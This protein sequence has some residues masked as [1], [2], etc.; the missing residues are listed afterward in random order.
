MHNLYSSYPD[1][2]TFSRNDNGTHFK[3]KLKARPNKDRFQKYKNR[4]FSD[5]SVSRLGA[6]PMAIIFVTLNRWLHVFR[7]VHC[8][9]VA[10]D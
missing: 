4:I 5:I 1:C 2:S 7:P 6:L 10:R 8:I 3:T 9:D